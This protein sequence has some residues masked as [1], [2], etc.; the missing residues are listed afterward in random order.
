MKL[1]PR[2][3]YWRIRAQK[4]EK[5]RD[6]ALQLAQLRYRNRLGRCA[7][8]SGHLGLLSDYV[9]KLRVEPWQETEKDFIV[10]QLRIDA[11]KLKL[12]E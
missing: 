5:E 8:I 4:L 7:G 9:A 3:R 6:E 1:N 2:W 10:D 11:E 12:K